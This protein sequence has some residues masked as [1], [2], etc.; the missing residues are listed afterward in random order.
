MM[1][2]FSHSHEKRSYVCKRWLEAWFATSY[3]EIAWYKDWYHVFL[4]MWSHEANLYIWKANK[5]EYICMLV[6]GLLVGLQINWKAFCE[7]M[8]Q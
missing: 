2:D 8:G 4:Y 7:Q 6:L 3:C 5:G 1:C